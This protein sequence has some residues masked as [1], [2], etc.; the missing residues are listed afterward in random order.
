MTYN[1]RFIVADT[2]TGGI[3][4]QLK[5]KATLE[6]SLTE[7][8]MVAVDNEKLEILN[9]DSWLIKPYLDDLI[10]EPMAAKVS[11][12]TKQMCEKE[13][14][15]IETVYKNVKSFILK[16]TVKTCKPIFVMQNKSFDIPFFQ[17]LFELFDDDFFK[18]ID[19]V[20]DTMEWSRMRWP[21]E[22]KHNLGVISQR[23]GLDH[24]E[25]H[26]ALPDTIITAEVWIYFLKHL[27]G[28]IGSKTE[29][30]P[31]RFR[32]TFKF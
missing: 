29:Q 15:D 4:A 8:A 17:G 24:T 21:M 11:G 26:R 31:K 3:P 30:K 5:K 22:S 9:K 27:R 12:I 7:I 20:E 18:Y 6:V 2:E 1:N 28:E 13:G 19:R 16:E 32:D 10:Y 14:M 23:C 25:S